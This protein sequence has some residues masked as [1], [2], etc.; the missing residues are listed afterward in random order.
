[1]K[2]ERSVG[3]QEQ[4][5]GRGGGRALSQRVNCLFCFRRSIKSCYHLH[6]SN[7][8]R[9]LEPFNHSIS[10][11]SL[12]S[13]LLIGVGSDAFLLCRKLVFVV[14]P[15]EFSQI[16]CFQLNF[17]FK[18]TDTSSDSSIRLR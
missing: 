18:V 3:G 2:A 13:S 5:N 7:P 4:V 17:W 15:H 12:C 11:R 16:R 8:A 6:T 1:M 10:A 14:Q 9:R